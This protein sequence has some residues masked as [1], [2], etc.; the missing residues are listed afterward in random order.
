MEGIGAGN[1]TEHTPE[2]TLQSCGSLPSNPLV[3]ICLFLSY[4][5]LFFESIF[6][7]IFVIVET[8]RMRGKK[9]WGSKQD[10]VN[11]HL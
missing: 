2:C 11:K 10:S 7:G 5:K 3:V 4:G 8:Q 6:W 1:V 9:K